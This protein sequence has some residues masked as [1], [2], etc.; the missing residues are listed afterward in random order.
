MKKDIK[1]L[2]F[3]PAIAPYRINFFNDIFDSFDT[4]ICLYDKNLADNKFDE[5]K[6]NAR[7]HFAPHYFL[8][9]LR[10]FG[11]EFHF[12]HIKYLMETDPDVVIVTE[13]G[14]ALWISKWYRKIRR[15]N[16][17]II[18]ICDDSIEMAEGR[19]TIRRVARNRGVK[20]L[21]GII[22]CNEL[23]MQFYERYNVPLYCFPIIQNEKE[24]HYR[25]EEIIKLAEGIIDQYQMI[26][27]RIFLFVGRLSP[28]KNLPYLVRSFIKAHVNHPENILFI[29]GGDTYKDPDL[30]IKLINIINDNQANEYIKIL[31]RKEGEELKAWYYA[32]QIL[33]LP[34]I[35]E[36]FGAVVGEALIA[37]EYVMV[38][39]VAGAACLINEDNGEI[40][41]IQKQYIDFSEMSRRVTTME[42]FQIKESKMKIDYVEKSEGLMNWVKTLVWNRGGKT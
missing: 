20:A 16:Y 15:K 33:V 14:E 5:E 22:L 2:I 27:H 17:V 35:Q 19:K 23:A 13:Y 6:L 31:G 10:I 36:A 39:S 40:I 1:V 18:T 24:F 9:H 21:D 4:T 42:E 32:C 8:R 29:I 7:I 25:D 3:H 37:G 28:E 38:S 11:R 34:S 30:R 41:D 26:G 12:G